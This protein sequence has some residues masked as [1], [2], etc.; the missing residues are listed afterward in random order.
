MAYREFQ[1]ERFVSLN[2]LAPGSRLVPGQKL[3]LVVYGN[4]RA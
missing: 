2:G 1:V 4:R 3:K